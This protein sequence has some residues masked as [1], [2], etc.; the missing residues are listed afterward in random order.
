MAVG[1]KAA[2]FAALMRILIQVFPNMSPD[3]ISILWV[4]A[5]L[6]MTLGNVVA[7]LQTNLKRMLA[8][9][10]IAHAGYIL[11]GIVSNSIAGLSA[12]LFYLVV[13]T[14]MNLVAFG[15]IISLS[16]KGDMRV[17]LDDFAGLG[18]RVPF[19]AAALSFAL[20]SLAGIPLTGGFIGKFYL[21]SAAIQ[22]GFIGL[23]IIGVLNSVVS[24]YYYFRVMVYMYMREPAE[25]APDPEPLGWSVQAVVGIL[26][27]IIV[28][29]GIHPDHIL[30]L[31]GSSSLALK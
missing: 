20:V 25:G 12:V 21:F 11:V 31:A 15:I 16:S 4:L 29:L 18:R 30:A 7:L 23:A 6:T 27:I 17:Q 8:Y 13:Y 19:A 10:A 9:S 5:I 24:V 2:G 14:V 3:W 28:F 22:K 26:V 1:P